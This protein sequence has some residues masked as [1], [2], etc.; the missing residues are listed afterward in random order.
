VRSPSDTLDLVARVKGTNVLGTVKALRANRER[1]LKLLPTRL[2]RY[3]EERILVSTWYPEADQIE[4]LRVLANFLPP[5]PNP[6]VVMGRMA[7]MQD[8]SGVYRGHV[9]P[10]DPRRTL[11]SCGALWRNYHDT[12]EMTASDETERSTII[13]LRGYRAACRE[14]CL[15]TAGYIVEIATQAGGRDV[16]WTKLGCFVDGAAECSWRVD[17]K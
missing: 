12:G 2:H 10:G 3:L 11:A 17:W 1:A 5:E 6:L 7:A 16:R 4:M 14:M 15:V 8:L 13:R 9:R